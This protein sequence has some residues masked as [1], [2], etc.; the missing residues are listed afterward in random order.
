M[1]KCSTA[2]WPEPY[3]VMAYL[4]LRTVVRDDERDCMLDDNT[5]NEMQ[6]QI[7]SPFCIIT[8]VKIGHYIKQVGA[9]KKLE[10][11][12]PSTFPHIKL[13][14][15]THSIPFIDSFSSRSCEVSHLSASTA[16]RIPHVSVNTASELLFLIF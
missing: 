7:L 2:A 13:T 16:S 1:C 11:T 8:H 14:S 5:I 12:L 3:G 6:H 10:C 9:L 15:R 4:V